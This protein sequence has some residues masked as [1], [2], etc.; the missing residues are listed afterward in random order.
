MRCGRAALLVE[1]PLVEPARASDA[2]TTG[3]GIDTPPVGIE[4]E[5]LCLAA[6]VA[7]PETKSAAVTTYTPGAAGVAAL[8]REA[9]ITS[10]ERS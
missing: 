9:G 7:L 3:T 4:N 10:W 6:I 2:A 5:K 8:V 1:D